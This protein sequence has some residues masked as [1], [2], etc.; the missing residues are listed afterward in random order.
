VLDHLKND[1]LNF[2]S[3]ELSTPLSGL[4]GVHMLDPGGDPQRQA[5]LIDILCHGYERLADFVN[6]ALAYFRRL[7]GTEDILSIAL[8]VT[9]VASSVAARHRPKALVEIDAPE[10]PVMV[11]T[12][13][14][15]LDRVLDTLLGN[16]V[17][18]SEDTARVRVSMR[19]EGG[20]AV[21]E[22][23]DH[24]RGFPPERAEDLF[25]P[26]TVADIAH[27]SQGTGL[28]LPLAR[29]ILEDYDATVV[30]HSE[31]EGRGATF[32]VRWPLCET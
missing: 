23:R 14:E 28:N 17:K 21:I 26:F 3:H 1:F 12:A 11:R 29:A 25:R 32:T 24:G 8:D 2:I 22:V 7:A 27:H 18:F 6:S 5:E 16:A 10:D 31:G 15:D 13:P 9:E 4:Q 30:A 20:H 19:P